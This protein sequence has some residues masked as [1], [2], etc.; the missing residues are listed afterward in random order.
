MPTPLNFY[1][2]N[3]YNATG[4]LK[5]DA[6]FTTDNS[7]K[8]AAFQGWLSDGAVVNSLN[9]A[10]ISE[11]I[12][13]VDTEGLNV[14]LCNRFAYTTMSNTK[15]LDKVDL[16]VVRFQG[17]INPLR[18]TITKGDF[19]SFT[20][21]ALSFGGYTGSRAGYGYKIQGITK[22]QEVDIINMVYSAGTQSVTVTTDSDHGLQ[23]GDKVIIT[24]VVPTAYNSTSTSGNIDVI[25][26]SNTTFRYSVLTNPGAYSSGGK[27]LKLGKTLILSEAIRG[28]GINT[29]LISSGTTVVTLAAPVEGQIVLG[30]R[31][32][33]SPVTTI[34]NSATTVVAYNSVTRQVTLSSGATT[35]ANPNTTTFTFEIDSS[36]S[37]PSLPIGATTEN[38]ATTNAFS[39]QNIGSVEFFQ[40]AQTPFNYY[41]PGDSRLKYFWSSY[42][43]PSFTLNFDGWSQNF[44]TG[45]GGINGDKG[46]LRFVDGVSGSQVFMLYGNTLATV[47]EDT[48][49]NI[50]KILNLERGEN[51]D[52]YSPRLKSA[53]LYI[54]ASNEQ[55]SSGSRTDLSRGSETPGVTLKKTLNTLKNNNGYWVGVIGGDLSEASASQPNKNRIETF[56]KD[57][58]DSNIFKISSVPA[59]QAIYRRLRADPRGFTPSVGTAKTA[60]FGIPI[61]PFNSTLYVGTNETGP[62]IDGDGMYNISLEYYHNFTYETPTPTTPITLNSSINNSVTTFTVNDASSLKVNIFIKIDSEYFAITEIVNN[63]LTVQRARLTS[64]A[65]S[66]SAGASVSIVPY[67]T[68]RIKNCNLEG[69]NGIY[70]AYITDSVLSTS[71][72][73]WITY[74]GTTPIPEI[75]PNGVSSFGFFGFVVNLTML[76]SV[77]NTFYRRS[78]YNY[79]YPSGSIDP[80]SSGIGDKKEVLATVR[81]N[82]TTGFLEKGTTTFGGKI[83]LYTIPGVGFYSGLSTGTYYSYYQDIIFQ[84]AITVSNVAGASTTITKVYDAGFTK[85]L[86]GDILETFV[87]FDQVKSTV[88]SFTYGD[89][90]TIYSTITAS[91][92]NISVTGDFGGIDV[93]AKI[94]QPGST[95]IEIVK[96]TQVIGVGVGSPFATQLEVIRGQLGTTAQQWPAGSIITLYPTLTLSNPIQINPSVNADASFVSGTDTIQLSNVS[97]TI[98][99]GQLIT[100][101]GI[102]SDTTVVDYEPTGG[103]LVLSKNTTAASGSGTPPATTQLTFTS[104]ISS[105]NVVRGKNIKANSSVIYYDSNTNVVTISDDFLGIPNVFSPAEPFVYFGVPNLTKTI[106]I[107][108]NKRNNFKDISA[109]VSFPGYGYQVGNALT[110]SPLLNPSYNIASAFWTFESEINPTGL[111]SAG[112]AAP[113]TFSIVYTERTGESS[114]AGVGAKFTVIR[115]ANGTYRVNITDLGSGYVLGESIVISGND[116]GGISPDNDLTITVGQIND[117][118]KVTM[119]TTEPHGFVPPAGR[120]SCRLLIKN[121]S[122]GAFNGRFEATIIDEFT[123]T[124]PLPD[125]P[126]SYQIGGTVKN[127]S[128]DVINDAFSFLSNKL[129]LNITETTDLE[130][131]YIRYFETA[132]VLDK[133]V[134]VT[135]DENHHL[136]STTGTSTFAAGASTITITNPVTTSQYDIDLSGSVGRAVIGTGIQENTIVTAVNGNTITLSRPTATAQAVAVTIRVTDRVNVGGVSNDTR[137]SWNEFN[138]PVTVLNDTQFQYT[139]LSSGNEGLWISGGYITDPRILPFGGVYTKN[140]DRMIF[141]NISDQDVGGE[142][143]PKT[144]D[145]VGSPP[146]ATDNIIPA[147]KARDFLVRSLNFRQ[148]SNDNDVVRSGSKHDFVVTAVNTLGI[149]QI[150]DA[151]ITAVEYEN[152]RILATTPHNFPI[153]AITNTSTTVTVT[154]GYAHPFIVGNN[155]LITGSS[156]AEYNGEF[157]ILTVPNTTSFTYQTVIAATTTQTIPTTT[158]TWSNAASTITVT[159]STGISLGQ[160]V[161]AT[162]IPYQTQVTEINGNIITISKNTTAAQA[163][164]ATVRFSSVTTGSKHHLYEGNLIDVNDFA[165]TFLNSSSQNDTVLEIVD[166]YNFY[167]GQQEQSDGAFLGKDRLVVTGVI[168]TATLPPTRLGS[169][170]KNSDIF[171]E[172]VDE[173]TVVGNLRNVPGLDELA[174][175]YVVNYASQGGQSLYTTFRIS[176]TQGGANEVFQKSISNI[177]YVQNINKATVFTDGPHSLQTDDIITISNVSPSA[178]NGNYRITK[179]SSSSFSYSPPQ[180]KPTAI[181]PNIEGS[182]L[183]NFNGA[184]TAATYSQTTNTIT[185]TSNGHGLLV[186]QT[187]YLDFTS[188]TATDGYYAVLTSAAN[189]FTVYRST[190]ATTSGNVSWTRAYS[191]VLALTN[192][193]IT[194]TVSANT[195]IGSTLLPVT[196]VTDVTI[197]QSVVDGSFN[198]GTSLTNRIQAGTRVINTVT[199]GAQLYI[200]INNPTVGAIFDGAGTDSQIDLIS[201]RKDSY[202]ITLSSVTNLHV[203]QLITTDTSQFAS[204]AII[205]NINTT[206]NTI[207]LSSPML[208]TIQTGTYS[209]ASGVATVTS[210]SHGL[211]IGDKIYLDATTGTETDGY[212]VVDTVPT[213]NTFTYVTSNGSRTGNTSFQKIPGR[214]IAASNVAQAKSLKVSSVTGVVAGYSVSGPS[215]PATTTVTSIDSA[216]NRVYLSE[217]LTGT[218]TQP[219]A[220]GSFSSGST[221]VLLSSITGTVAVGQTVSGSGIASGTTITGYNTATSTITLSLATT[222]ASGVGDPPATT[223]LTFNDTI[224]FGVGSYNNNGLI[225][226][227]FT[228]IVNNTLQRRGVY[229]NG[230][231]NVIPDKLG[232]DHVGCAKG[233]RGAI[234]FQLGFAKRMSGTAGSTTL[235]I[236]SQAPY[237]ETTIPSGILS[238]YFVY[239]EGIQGETRIL[240]TTNNTITIDKPLLTTITDEN[241]GISRKDSPSIFPKY[242]VEFGRVLG[243]TFAEWLFKVA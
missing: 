67:C 157:T 117:L 103:I 33:T 195:T 126:G 186:G 51:G 144:E 232:W 141:L 23:T 120:T 98:F 93:Y 20:A 14:N 225:T 5:V 49:N 182:T 27:L 237:N 95:T 2:K 176:L 212:Y 224:I 242:T 240:S 54:S 24:R 193:Q 84:S 227:V 229:S 121:V 60:K 8:L 149:S 113:T 215:L 191:T 198:R 200:E 3:P 167:Y 89:T 150:T 189:S 61:D 41:V 53:L 235:T 1:K 131:P 63:Q 221:T 43:A 119:Q 48:F 219:T 238:G 58:P 239:G 90:D 165:N 39:S 202:A 110:P 222:A 74:K 16:L 34:F 214:I 228:P 159:S 166:D 19:I 143:N 233:S 169:F 30:Q 211:S 135:T 190:S 148:R 71:K 108:V 72:S 136:T 36:N 177:E 62:G 153:S 75:V 236:S 85:V 26:L 160:Y 50:D 207:G 134:T 138:A 12:G 31:V 22:N 105:N 45:A 142:I 164:A 99:I 47:T 92:T 199:V 223:L 68:L 29:S 158:A 137:V 69:L 124:Y 171:P 156:V 188:G 78:T 231:I 83:S 118:S 42:A 76:F 241:V 11:N 104:T 213:A 170:T 209:T 173:I 175:H 217:R 57:N 196:S 168:P 100:G 133:V 18:S 64:L 55:G 139:I 37:S 146:V 91:D 122:P 10:L 197:G 132:T 94:N 13:V 80:E 218:F 111:L 15:Y 181:L 220:S 38:V 161:I 185:V 106:D 66:H 107:L 96:I 162:G 56:L 44:L 230:S 226:P 21:N 234:F 114:G 4:A 174:D 35:T 81:V 115:D 163:T 88:G 32:I 25:R 127:I 59:E 140:F 192:T 180:V 206:T 73:F 154:T 7:P 208:A 112:V 243:K 178:Y 40:R 102:P 184:T 194:K 210:T 145:I 97:G 205:E 6:I 116:L 129:F 123:F 128:I 79:L 77:P 204:T 28:R 179:I 183:Y 17:F 52:D 46:D 203:G 216:N 87:I 86:K 130:Y 70:K 152:N 151:P 201:S 9:D 65:A 155:I 109:T 125:D 82:E 187:V 147:R 101:S 172:G